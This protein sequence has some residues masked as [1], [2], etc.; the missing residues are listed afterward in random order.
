[1]PQ[2]LPSVET[3]LGY[4]WDQN[5]SDLLLTAGS[6]PMIRVDGTLHS[7]PDLP[8]LTPA[9]TE[10]MARAIL[11]EK[12]W[13]EYSNGEEV[14][15]SFG[16]QGKARIRGNAFRQRN[17][18]ALA[19]R[20]MPRSIPSYDD[21][22]VPEVVRDWAKQLQGL[23]LVTGPTG[24]GKSTTIAS[25]IEW[26]CANRPVH[27]ITI[28]DP[29]E[30][31]HR[32]QLA[33]IDQRGV[34]EDTE[35]FGQALRSALREDPDVILVGEMRDLESIRFAITLAETGHLVFASL[36][37]NDAP[38][39]LDR[40]IDV[41]PGDEQ[42]LVRTQLAIC[43]TGVVYQRLLPRVDGGR[44]AAFEV[45]VATPPVR[46]LIKEGRTNQLRNQVMLGSHQ[47]MQTLESSLSEL[48]KSGL[49]AYDQA[50]AYSL[51][52]SEIERH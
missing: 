9:D 2:E 1:M 45:L 36:H 6:A 43:L 4:V 14:D 3:L 33:A 24:S 10:A 40:L 23:V 51:F 50:T 26:I 25:M 48:V 7:A 17:S 27:V 22:G 13:E 20:M 30:Y 37:T 42:A 12:Q 28:E 11:S 19:L 8:R 41:F 32:H 18:V 52:P 34:G 15:F 35:S 38:Q 47:G 31:V 21:I 5:G 49:V 39:S 29:I 16:W 44:V 46:N